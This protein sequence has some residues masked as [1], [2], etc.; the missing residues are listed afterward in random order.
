MEYLV[1]GALAIALIALVAS[2]WNDIQTNRARRHAGTWFNDLQRS[3]EEQERVTNSH[4]KRLNDQWALVAGARTRLDKL[5]R[6]VPHAK[7]FMDLQIAVN[8]LTGQQLANLE[9]MYEKLIANG[10]FKPER[11]SAR[12]NGGTLGR[13]ENVAHQATR[14]NVTRR[15]SR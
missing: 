14:K 4:T 10:T 15:G 1:G 6:A 9:G 12:R 5:E 7:E 2:V 11:R 3:M 8:D 13:V